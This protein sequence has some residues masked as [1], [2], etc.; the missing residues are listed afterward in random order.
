MRIELHRNPDDLVLMCGANSTFKLKIVKA[1]FFARNV[2][3]NNGIYLEHIE[4]LEKELKP[5]VY[6]LRRVAMHTFTI[7]TGLLSH[8]EANL[9][10]GTLP[11]RIILALV[12][13][14]AYD[15]ARN[16][17]PFNFVHK[18]LK[19]CSLQ[20]NGKYV[21][22]KPYT[23]DFKNHR[24]LRSYYAILESTG[25]IY[26]DDGI[27]ISREDFDKG[28]SILTWDL[29]PDLGESGCYHVIKTGNIRL[30]LQFDTALDQPIN[31]IVYA[32]YGGYIKIDKNRSVMTQF[33]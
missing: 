30:E 10:D 11:K 23:L 1:T 8:N 25:Q 33:H 28:Y 9:F 5:A 3:I 15:G 21:P 16:E 24:T 4:K 27:D 32:E 2:K 13:S 18:D 26:K 7:G 19:Y 17:N 22:Q 20:V 14:S 12:N 6:P 31:A 29:T